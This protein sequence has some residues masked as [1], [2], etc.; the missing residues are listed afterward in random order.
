MFQLNTR[1]PKS[2]RASSTPTRNKTLI[3]SRITSL[4]GHGNRLDVVA[5][6]LDLVLHVRRA[7][8]L[9]ARGKLHPVYPSQSIS[10]HNKIYRHDN[11][12]KK[13]PGE[14]RGTKFGC[15]AQRVTRAP[16]YERRRG[17]EMGGGGERAWS[18][19]RIGRAHRSFT[20]KTKNTPKSIQL[21]DE[22][23]TRLHRDTQAPRAPHA[24]NTYGKAVKKK[25][26][27][28]PF[29]YRTQQ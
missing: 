13:Q 2:H 14:R 25:R 11:T 9:D 8:V 28:V 29:Q 1:Q 24:Q 21:L 12:T 10:N 15:S 3:L 17:K 22:D 18:A 4:T 6:E 27:A 19:Q 23:Y 5:A 26:T 7:D 20:R 16:T